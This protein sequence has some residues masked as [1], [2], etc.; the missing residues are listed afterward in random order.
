MDDRLTKELKGLVNLIITNWAGKK[1]EE[2]AITQAHDAILKLVPGE[3][4]IIKVLDNE[5]YHIVNHKLAHAVLQALLG[6]LIKE[7][8]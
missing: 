3:E 1:G 6:G 5:H 7:E 4:E 2:L 8:K